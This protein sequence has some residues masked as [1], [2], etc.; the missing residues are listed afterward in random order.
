MPILS[1]SVIFAPRIPKTYSIF[2][3]ILWIRDSLAPLLF[4]IR[5][6]LL[7]S[8]RSLVIVPVN[9]APSIKLF[10]SGNALSALLISNLYTPSRPNAAANLARSSGFSLLAS[11][12]TVPS[13]ETISG[14]K[15]WKACLL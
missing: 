12:I 13:G 9:G 2:L 8:N 14:Y 7:F 4:L 6:C 1:S 15:T 5:Y 10:L 11:S 3:A